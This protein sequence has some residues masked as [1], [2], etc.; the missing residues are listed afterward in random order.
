MSKMISILNEGV[1][2]HDY[3]FKDFRPVTILDQ[4]Q[5]D[6]PEPVAKAMLRD[7]PHLKVTGTI[8][9]AEPAARVP[10]DAE[11]KS[12]SRRLAAQNPDGS[13]NVNPQNYK[14]KEEFE[15][16]LRGS[17]DYVCSVCWEHFTTN[18]TR[19]DHLKKKH[20]L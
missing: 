19:K 3:I 7:F 5:A 13:I 20:K 10:K 15:D 17:E 11:S 6:V 1:P 4:Q 14:T 16:A 8:T 12:N 9:G 18:E 2:V